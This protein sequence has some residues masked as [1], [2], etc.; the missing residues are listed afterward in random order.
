MNV[1]L[2]PESLSVESRIAFKVLT[3][4]ETANIGSL[5]SNI[6]R[7]T[8]KDP[9]PPSQLMLICRMLSSYENR[10]KNAENRNT[11]QNQDSFIGLCWCWQV[12]VE[13]SSTCV[14]RWMLKRQLVAEINT[15]PWSFLRTFWAKTNNFSQHLKS[16]RTQP[17]THPLRTI[18]N[19]LPLALFGKIS[20]VTTV[21]LP[22]GGVQSDDIHGPNELRFH[23]SELRVLL[24]DQSVETSTLRIVSHCFYTVVEYFYADHKPT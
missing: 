19:F 7:R 8:F 18:G 2:T 16:T 21:F 3:V 9:P 4:N 22:A 11:E 5:R 12:G 10:H 6:W 17:T 24:P 1:R 20:Y 13:F 23:V 15:F 14:R